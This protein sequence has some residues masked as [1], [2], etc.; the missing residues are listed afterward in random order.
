MPRPSL[1]KHTTQRPALAVQ[2]CTAERDAVSGHL[3]PKSG[4]AGLSTDHSWP[5]TAADGVSRGDEKRLVLTVHHYFVV[6]Y[7]QNEP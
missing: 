1:E 5:P 4:C 6:L 2:Y 3:L 7:I